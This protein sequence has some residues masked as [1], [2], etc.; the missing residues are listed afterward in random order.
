MIFA[1]GMLAV[2]VCLAA[3]VGGGAVRP[4]QPSGGGGAGADPAAVLDD[5]HDAA[6][7]ADYARYFSHW[8]EES[9]FLGTDATERWVGNQF[10]AFAK[11]IFDKGKGWTYRPHDRHISGAGET[12]FFDE[13]L[14]NEKLG[15]CRG[16]GVLRRV[17]AEWKVMQYNLSI[18]V[19]NEKALQVAELIRAAAGQPGSGPGGGGPGSSLPGVA[20]GSPP[21]KTG[22]GGGR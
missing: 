4:G 9:V 10:G 18:S 19:P 7:K 16:S 15:L 3:V 1:H 2:G 13:L 22:G 8:T 6:A 21:P 12:V 14:D 5:F 11:P 20:P 17:G